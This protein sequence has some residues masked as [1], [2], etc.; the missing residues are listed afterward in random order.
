MLGET[1]GLNSFI[2]PYV[3]G[4]LHF[5]KISLL[6]LVVFIFLIPILLTNLL[7]RTNLYFN[8]FNNDFIYSNT[9]IGLAVGDIE[10]V[11]RNARL[12]RQAM[13]V[14]IFCLLALI[15]IFYIILI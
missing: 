8:L 5:G 13:Q 10:S 15:T 3:N 9:Q 4:S 2:I 7:V 12:K 11:Q 1:D 6:F 14:I